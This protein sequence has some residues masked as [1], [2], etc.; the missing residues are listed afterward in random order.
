[1]ISPRSYSESLT[2]SEN[3]L[4]NRVK[5]YLKEPSQENVHELR[6]SIRQFLTLT[7]LL[8]KKIRNKKQ[9]R[10]LIDGYEKLLR[11]N[12][13][14]RDIDIILSKLPR[15]KD[16]QAYSKLAKKLNGARESSLKKAQKFAS[17]IKQPKNSSVQTTDLPAKLVKKRFEKT[18]SS[19]AKSL[20][21][22]LRI[23]LREPKNTSELHKLRED[24]RKLRFTL[25][26]D[27]SNENSKLLPVLTTWQ[28][29]LG[30]IRDSDVFIS[31]FE[32]ERA[33]SKFEK[34]LEEERAG[35]KDGYERFLEIA[36]E[37]PSF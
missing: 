17:S 36:K 37:S 8:P 16:D 35:R 2:K 34:V 31:R 24:S 5:S 27:D 7:G 14:I 1:M 13:K 3:A 28:D 32:H 20:K 9:L 12:A 22:H 10:R 21:K 30:K 25:E 33:G 19:L 15:N 29:V 18:K 11:L 23:V 6:T 4:S 26:I